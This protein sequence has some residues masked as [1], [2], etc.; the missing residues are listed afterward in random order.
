MA[1]KQNTEQ[2]YSQGFTV[3]CEYS[4]AYKKS[5]LTGASFKV[6]MRSEETGRVRHSHNEP[7][8]TSWLNARGTEIVTEIDAL[9]RELWGIMSDENEYYDRG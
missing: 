7:I 1:I 8:N 5:I 6:G 9:A 2:P 3:E 4:D